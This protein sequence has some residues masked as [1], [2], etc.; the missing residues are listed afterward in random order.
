MA[1]HSIS[2]S[3]TIAAP[4]QRVWQV[5]TDLDNA[6]VTLPSIT[7]IERLTDGPYA[8]GTRWLETRTMMGRAETHEMTVT[9]AVAPQRTVVTAVTDGVRYTTTMELSPDPTGTRLGITFAAQHPDPTGLQRILWTIMGPL[10]ALFTRRMLRAE[11]AEI[12][13]AART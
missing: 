5:L 12:G 8:V 4:P 1:G 11:L 10:G 7:E 6:A 2:V 13:A 9:E 3:G